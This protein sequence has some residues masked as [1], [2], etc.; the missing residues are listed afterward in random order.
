MDL[1]WS[2]ESSEDRF[3]ANIERLSQVLGHADR[4]GPFRYH[5]AR[6][7]CR[8]LRRRSQRQRITWA[9]M[10]VLVARYFP[11]VRVIHPWPARR[12]DAN[13]PR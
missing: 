1:R 6:M 9:R 13:H 8:H 11:P 12:F 5:L 10:K 7:W 2:D 4:L 3:E